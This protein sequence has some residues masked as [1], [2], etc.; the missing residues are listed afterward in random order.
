MRIATRRAA[1]FDAAGWTGELRGEV[2]EFFD[3][4]ASEWHTRNSPQRT[5]VVIDALARGL[6]ETGTRRGLAVEVG[7]GIGSY[8]ELIAQ[9]FGA[10][11]AVDLSLEMLKRAPAG[12]GHRVQ[13]DGAALPVPDRSVAAVV[14]INALLFPAEVARVLIA[15]GVLLWVNS[16]GEQTPIYLSAED[17]LAALPGEWTGVS[18]RAGEGHWCVLRRAGTDSRPA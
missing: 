10:V 3:R 16:S 2:T 9:R 14:L 17:L 18:S 12:P 4:L 13:A 15:D 6:A 1:G 5:A 11:L 8:S 7:S